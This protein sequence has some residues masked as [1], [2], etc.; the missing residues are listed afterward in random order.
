MR[1]KRG[2]TFVEV[3]FAVFL[4]ACSAAIVAATLPVANVSRAR[5][6]LLNKASG[7]AQ[8]Q[9]EAIRGLGYANATV[10]QLS[11]FGLIDSTT[12]VETNTYAFSNVD[13]PAL[14][15]PAR[16]LPGGTG[17]VLIEQAELDLRRIVV[18]VRWNERGRNR[19]YVIGTLLANL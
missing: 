16:I 19:T 1:R 17:T 13:A 3:L 18:T 14:D 4:V 7:L 15:N 12:P 10:G 6:S 11:S 8:K 9:L 2:Y 5:A